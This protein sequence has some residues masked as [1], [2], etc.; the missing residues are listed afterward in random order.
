MKK[1]QKTKK[2]K[3]KKKREP[4]NQNKHTERF[5]GYTMETFRADA[6]KKKRKLDF[7]FCLSGFATL[8]SS[9]VTF[10]F[11]IVSS[12]DRAVL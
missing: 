6:R 3:K 5:R 12:H 11:G 9:S 8:T 7:F 4:T 2:P 1:N 10:Y